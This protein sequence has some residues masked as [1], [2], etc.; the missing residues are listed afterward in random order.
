VSD[1]IPHPIQISGIH[2][3]DFIDHY[4]ISEAHVGFPRII[5]E[6]VSWPVG[7]NEYDVNRR[8][9]KRC[10]VV[11]AV[12]NEDIRLLLGLGENFLIIHTRIY[13]RTSFDMGFILLTFL[14]GTVKTVEIL[15]ARKPLDPL[16]NK[17]SIWHG[18]ANYH[19]GFAL[20]SQYVAYLPGGLALATSGSPTS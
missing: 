6:L 12:P 20:L 5:A 10:V 18:V 8:F 3:I 2:R 9:K 11:S 7:I 19:H 13:D 15:S 14:D 17:V 4:R 16:S 1:V